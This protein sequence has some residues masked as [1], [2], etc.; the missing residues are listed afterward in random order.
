MK[1]SY[2]AAVSHAASTGSSNATGTQVDP[3]SRDL[4]RRTAAIFMGDLSARELYADE[5]SADIKDMMDEIS[6][7][8]PGLIGGALRNK[9]LGIL[10]AKQDHSLYRERMSDLL[11]DVPMCVLI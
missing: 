1:V 2:L 9:A 4:L 5:N 3:K 6:P 10:W 8:Y 11:N 7:Q